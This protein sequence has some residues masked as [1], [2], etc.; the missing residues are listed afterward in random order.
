MRP[1]CKPFY[2]DTT[3]WDDL[4]KNLQFYCI[5]GKIFLGIIEFTLT[6]NVKKMNEE[7]ESPWK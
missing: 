4:R 5:C 2:L 7:G 1:Q 6:G 3:E